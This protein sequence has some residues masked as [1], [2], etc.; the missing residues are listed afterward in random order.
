MMSKGARVSRQ[1]I[2]RKVRQEMLADMQRCFRR[3]YDTHD[4]RRVIEQICQM[5]CRERH[6]TFHTDAAVMTDLAVRKD[7]A[8]QIRGFLLPPREDDVMSPDLADNDVDDGV[9]QPDDSAGVEHE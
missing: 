8:L 6:P 5:I 3:V 7:V 1:E 2:N 4:G 9:L